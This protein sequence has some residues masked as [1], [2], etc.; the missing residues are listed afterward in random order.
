MGS[1]TNMTGLLGAFIMSKATDS[2]EERD[3][4]LESQIAGSHPGHPAPYPV[5]RKSTGSGVR[6]PQ[7][8]SV[9]HLI[10]KT[11]QNFSKSG[12]TFKSEFEKRGGMC[13]DPL[14][15]KVF[16]NLMDDPTRYRTRLA[17]LLTRYLG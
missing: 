17:T 10:S 3:L 16:Y 2:L 12:I 4:L 15:E 5:H 9:S 8:Q 7:W 6:L 13:A 14:L 1:L 11:V